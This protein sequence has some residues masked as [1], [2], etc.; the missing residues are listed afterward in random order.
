M[1]GDG[2]VP[3]GLRLGPVAAITSKALASARGPSPRAGA[4]P[5]SASDPIAAAEPLGGASSWSPYCRL[6]R[7]DAVRA[8]T[9]PTRLHNVRQAE[10]RAASLRGHRRAESRCPT[11]RIPTP[12][13][14][15]SSR[16]TSSPTSRRPT[17][18]VAARKPTGEGDP[19][20]P[21]APRRQG[22]RPSACCPAA[23]IRRPRPR[24]SRP[25]AAS[26]TPPLCGL[27]GGLR[28]RRPGPSTRRCHVCR[29]DG[30]LAP[31]ARSPGGVRQGPVHALAH[32]VPDEVRPALLGRRARWAVVWEQWDRR[33][34]ERRC[35]RAT[36]G[37]R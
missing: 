12:G 8:P 29:T 26:S 17:C 35:S 2:T 22:R 6:V 5:G 3:F 18:G 31:R 32:L 4:G 30:P 13:R 27:L 16:R 15:S 24:R 37:S 11:C 34:R 28:R 9:L 1:H 36:R 23:R 33:A 25:R 19:P 14:A 20:R 10:R 21:P 7:R